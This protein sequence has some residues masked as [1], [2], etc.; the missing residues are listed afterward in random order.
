MEII[1]V[2]NWG[3]P[4]EAKADFEVQL[5]EPSVT[6]GID[7]RIS[8]LENL[9]ITCWEWAEL[10]YHVRQKLLMDDGRTLPTSTE[11]V[12]CADEANPIVRNKRSLAYFCYHF[13]YIFTKEECRRKS[14]LCRVILYQLNK[15]SRPHA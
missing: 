5:V 10:L 7:A 15:L 1:R 13:A 14:S 12:E 3:K 9:T 2:N 11:E 6:P 4:K 8:K